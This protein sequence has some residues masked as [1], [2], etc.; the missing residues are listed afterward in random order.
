MDSKFGIIFITCCIVCIAISGCLTQQR[1]VSKPSCD[2]ELETPGC[3]ISAE[4]IVTFFAEEESKYISKHRHTIYPEDTAIKIEADEPGGNFEYCL[5]NGDYCFINGGS[6]K[7]SVTLYTS[8]MARA[9]V[10]SISARGGFLGDKAG[11][12]VDPVSIAG[13]M[14]QP[15]DMSGGDD[16]R[17]SQKVYREISSNQI[18]WVEIKNSENNVL[19]AARSYNVRNLADSGKFMPASIDIYNTDSSGRP[20]NRIMNIEYTSFELLPTM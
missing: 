9:I 15:I 4:C 11:L 5:C 1:E 16:S 6:S 12:M 10:L 8:E 20:S 13:R 2:I 19:I 3:V 7:T 17:V 18:D 14:Y